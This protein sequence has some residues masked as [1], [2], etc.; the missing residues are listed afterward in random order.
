VAT[1]GKDVSSKTHKYV[2]DE[3]CRMYCPQTLNQ[4]QVTLK[5]LEEMSY[6]L[7]LN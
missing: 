3:V 2:G 5:I 1:Y 7:T 6:V 4:H